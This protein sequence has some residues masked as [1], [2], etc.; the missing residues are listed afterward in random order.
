MYPRSARELI[1]IAYDTELVRR[2]GSILS[3][4]VSDHLAQLQQLDDHQGR[5]PVQR[6]CPPGE[7]I[8]RAADI[9]QASGR[10]DE[11]PERCLEE[12]SDRFGELVRI[13]LRRGQNLHHPQCAGHQV[14]ASVPMAGLF[15]AVSTLTNQ[16]Q[17]V[18]EMGPWCVSV[19]R[20][21]LARVGETIGFAPGSFAGLITSGGSL[22]N[23]T[24]LLAAR[25]QRCPEIWKSGFWKSGSHACDPA[26]VLVVHRDAHYCVERAAGVMGIGT[27]HIVYVPTDQQR[28]M[29][30]DALDEILIELTSRKV[31]VIAVVAV[32][33]TTP[34]GAFD[35]ME[36]IA[37]TCRR[38][39][40]WFHVDAAHG[41][42]LCFSKRHRQLVAGLH[43]AD[44]VVV[45]A[46]K[47]MFVPAVCAMVFYRNKHHRLAA[48]HQSAPY[49]F[50]PSAPEMA[51]YDN[52]VVTFECTKR[53]AALGLWGLW[54]MFGP[55]LFEAM[56]D[57]TIESARLFHAKID[58][59]DA[60]QALCKPTCNI[61]AFRYLPPNHDDTDPERVDLL[62]LQIRRRMLEQGTAY[63]TQTRIDG[64]IYLR[65][66][67]MNPLTDETAIDHIIESLHETARAC[68]MLS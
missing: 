9:M 12:L 29:R 2:C 8:Q 6:W 47:M 1:S 64:R 56:I 66:T 15:D 25:N 40:V 31:P 16:V 5:K 30:A 38:H 20:A 44:S 43:L 54:S 41:G 3:E 65:S 46:H 37:E 51:E 62:Q 13:C 10:R 50:D 59:D 18:Y 61:V 24:A 49:L 35:P 48:F 52:A 34:T 7:N 17:G 42:A 55:G 60:L 39:D 21:V 14:P 19:E 58:A 22:A 63:L 33:C 27:D 26:P 36:A 28:R 57:Q 32:A 4:V 53:A 68:L 11:D 67:I 45:D 23:L